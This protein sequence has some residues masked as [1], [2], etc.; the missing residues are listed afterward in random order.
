MG[1][2]SSVDN[3]SKVRAQARTAVPSKIPPCSNA[4]TRAQEEGDLQ[5]V[6]SAVEVKS[7]KGD[8]WMLKRELFQELEQKYGPFDLDGAACVEGTNAQ[9]PVNCSAAF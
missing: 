1:C 8:D 6:L 2:A 4:A 5:A 3:P 7:A 9:L